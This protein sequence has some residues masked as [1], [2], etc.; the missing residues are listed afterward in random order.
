MIVLGKVLHS[1]REGIDFDGVVISSLFFADDLVLISGTMKHGLERML[2][3]VG[4]FCEGMHMKL[5]V[6][7]LSLF[8]G[9]LQT[10]GDGRR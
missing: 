2:H 10:P 5:P 3:V 8:Q 7:K 9:V 4:R 1:L 6:S